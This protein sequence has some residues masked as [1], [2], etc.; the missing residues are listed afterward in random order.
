M[1]HLRFSTSIGAGATVNVI[2]GWQ[3]EYVPYPAR[4]K[5]LIRSPVSTLKSTLFSGS[6]TIQEE[7]PVQAGG[8]AGGTPYDAHT[9]P[10][11]WDASGGDDSCVKHR[12]A[13]AR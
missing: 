12:V 11:I 7:S 4:I 6:E 13:D 10:D 1:P 5:M 2:Q 8:T 9:P 3:Y